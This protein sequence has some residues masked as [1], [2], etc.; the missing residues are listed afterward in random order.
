MNNSEKSEKSWKL[1]PL[2][3]T[4]KSNKNR[5]KPEKMISLF[6]VFM[7]KDVLVPLNKVL[8]SGYIGQGPKVE[9]FEEL[10]KTHFGNLLIATTNSATSGAHIALKM[11]KTGFDPDDEVLA[12]P[13]TC[14]ATNFPILANGLKIK[15]VDVDPNT[16]NMDLDDLKRKIS[17][18]TK[19][20]MPVHWGGYPIDL[21][22]IKNIQQD[23]MNL[24]GFS[25]PVIEDCAH[26]FGSKYKNKYL[27]NHGN[28]CSYSLQAIKH[29]T[30]VDG[31]FLILP[32]KELYDRT[33]LLR[34]YGIDRNCNAKDFRCLHPST[35]VRFS[36]RTTDKIS[37]IVKNK[38]DK[39]ILVNENGVFVPRKIK[40]WITSS[41]GERYFL[42]LTTKK[43]NKRFSTTIT[44][45]HK[46][47][48]KNRGWVR[49][50]E[51]N[52]NEFILTSFY[53]P[54]KKQKELIIG[55]L[56]GDSCI[57][58]KKT[59]SIA[60]MG[61]MS[62]THSLAQREYNEL[63]ING[64]NDL[65]A[66]TQI[67][68]PNIDKRGVKSNGKITYFTK[69]SPYFGDLRNEF[70]KD[71]KK[72]IP[73][74]LIKKYYSDFMLA[75]WFMDD[76]RTQVSNS[77]EKLKFN[78][79]ISTNSFNKEDVE[80]LVDLL[81]IKGYDCYIYNTNKKN[82]KN[83]GYKIYFTRIGSEKLLNNI[84]KYVPLTMR[85]KV[86]HKYNNYDNKLWI[87]DKPTGYYDNV[88]IKKVKNNTYKTTYCLEVDSEHPNFQ[89]SAIVVHNCEDDISEWGYKMHMNDVNA[90]IGIHNYP[91]VQG[92]IDKHQDN[93][94][95]YNEE[96]KDIPGVELLEN[97]PDR[98]SAYWIYTIKVKDQDGFMS[99]MKEC[100]IM[101][102]RVHERND[103]HS[104][105]AEFKSHLPNLDKLVKEMI[106][107]PNGWWITKEERQYIVDCIK[108]GW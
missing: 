32:N 6:K 10:L 97:N 19:I 24:Y 59:K 47:L 2:K 45:D 55:S 87:L 71:G 96:L 20:I 37:N 65:I 81:K 28:I 46:V 64:L 44:N 8:M 57:T 89:T 43:L 106:C 93:A 75:V 100:N 77:F 82:F 9:E 33:K 5:N 66:T 88:I 52:K 18:K 74:K 58:V 7:S 68:P 25:P 84:S 80:W 69:S 34:W 51:L 86:G 76:G 61:V 35:L 94:N 48:T 1:T 14:T 103:K 15:W 92:I 22:E 54:N 4:K 72:I 70:Y 50:D 11:L 3:I 26:S 107:I 38:I 78:C 40:N 53:E 73:K 83:N 99:H 39:E 29:F 42:N 105:M 13:L 91:H 56:L 31:G 63:K 49:C 30:A 101:V 67:Y 60:T 62:E 21:D 108:E 104:C 23:T 41:L 36:D 17:P 16:C 27:G 12:T 98:E 102:S 79:D 85:Y 95:F 90:T